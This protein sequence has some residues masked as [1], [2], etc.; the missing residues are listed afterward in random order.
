[1]GGGDVLLGPHVI[2]VGNEWQDMGGWGSDGPLW[3]LCLPF[4]RPQRPHPGS[5]AGRLSWLSI[6]C[7]CPPLG[8]IKA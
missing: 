7:P 4:G 1:M 3:S 6:V 8:G 5:R 2:A